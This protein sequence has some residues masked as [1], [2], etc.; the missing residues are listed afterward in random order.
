M[1]KQTKKSHLVKPNIIMLVMKQN[2]VI[3]SLMKQ[4]NDNTE[5]KVGKQSNMEMLTS[6]VLML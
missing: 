5:F 1:N 6:G 4:E 2:I 3:F